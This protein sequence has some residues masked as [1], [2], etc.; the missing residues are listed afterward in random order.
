M[1]H[2]LFG[3]AFM[4]PHMEAHLKMV[5]CRSLLLLDH[6]FFGS[7]SL[8]M[9]LKADPSCQ[10]A[11]SD[12]RAL[13][14]NPA[15]VGV[16]PRDKLKGLLGHLVMHGVC[17][18]YRRRRDRDPD[19]WNAA[20]DYAINWILLEAGLT[21]P[22]GYLDKSEWRGKTADEIFG[23][24]S[25]QNNDSKWEQREGAK[26]PHEGSKTAAHEADSGDQGEDRDG[27]EAGEKTKSLDTRVK[28]ATKK[29]H[30]CQGTAGE[31]ESCGEI[32]DPPETDS[33]GGNIEAAEDVENQWKIA[34]AQAAMQAKSMGD[35]PASLARM[36]DGALSPKLDWRR[37]LGRFID[38]SAR[39]DYALMPPN[40]RYLHRGLYLPSM[41]SE[42]LPDAVVA[43][44]TSGS[45]S[46]RE[47]AQF[48]AELGAIVSDCAMTVHLLFC[49]TRV[50]EIRKL[51]R[52]DLPFRLT[53]KGGGGTDFRPAFQWVRE[54]GLQPRYMIY[55]TDLACNRFPE[56]PDFPV[57][58]AHT[59]QGDTTPPFGEVIEI[60]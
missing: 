54:Q 24:L 55:L 7:L 15:Y 17:G 23:L 52:M 35:L 28:N 13:A 5:K 19:Q 39:N 59:G 29:D 21:L 2:R 1:G 11:W 18:H 60:R 30:R 44:D 26:E 4:S 53:Y 46:D 58:W 9:P 42:E 31:F 37:L 33:P 50:T 14:Y 43:V 6:P 10:T 56:K 49:D 32:R 20:C 40:R 34:L 27:D 22:D 25:A 12:G 36:I 48:T 38:A 16:L 8:R 51:H 3:C 47:L 57:L 45:V 41:R